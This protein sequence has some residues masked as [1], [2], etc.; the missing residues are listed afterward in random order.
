M[1]TD[2][3]IRNAAIQHMNEAERR[4]ALDGKVLRGKDD[5]LFLDNDANQVLK[6]HTGE[7]RFS[8]KDL[9]DWR[10]LLETRSAWLERHGIPYFLLIAPNQHSIYPEQLPEGVE[11]SPERPVRQ[12]VE[13]LD[14]RGSSV[15]LI[16][17]TPALTEAKRKKL[18]YSKTDSHWNFYGAF[19]TYDR[20]MEEVGEVVEVNRL[21]EDELDFAEVDLIGG[22]GYKV[23]PHESSTFVMV[24]HMPKHARLISDNCVINN[25][26]LVELSCAEAPDTTCL[27]LGDSFSVNLLLFLAESFRHL[28]YG[29]T[30]S[31]DFDLVLEHKPDVVVS[32]ITE[33]FMIKVP[34]DLPKRSVHQMAREKK[35]RGELRGA[36]N[37][38]LPA[39]DA[40]ETQLQQS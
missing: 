31:L 34:Y 12:L 36:M 27:F 16:D 8:E 13:H 30:T 24:R 35:E 2:A 22:L 15:R 10:V 9:E 38:W 1:E 7:I 5:W 33:R 28:V 19:V 39:G 26:S 21:S 40:E 37:W 14:A 29:H 20:L 25:G 4:A 32:L 18:V 23:E 6:Q 11:L 17:P 3:A